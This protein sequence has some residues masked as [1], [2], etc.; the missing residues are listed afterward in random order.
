MESSQL[1]IL[2]KSYFTNILAQVY[3]DGGDGPVPTVRNSNSAL[4]PPPAY[5]SALSESS[6]HSRLIIPM[7]MFPSTYLFIALMPSAFSCCDW[8]NLPAAPLFLKQL[9]ETRA[10][11]R[12]Q[13]K[14]FQMAQL[15]ALRVKWLQIYSLANLL[16]AFHYFKM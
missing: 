14:D 5:Y 3:F 13:R 9:A 12:R 7:R 8:R 1:I 10:V 16:T 4:T 15:T 2:F 11:L 6:K